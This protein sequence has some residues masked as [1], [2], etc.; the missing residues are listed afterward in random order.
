[1]L[2]TFFSSVFFFVK[3]YISYN[4]LDL[5]R[6]VFFFMLLQLVCFC[7]ILLVLRILVSF[8][9]LCIYCFPFSSL[10]L[11]L[12]LDIH[13][14]VTF[15]LFFVAFFIKF[16]TLFVF[17]CYLITHSYTISCAV[18][19]FKFYVFSSILFFCIFFLLHN[20]LQL[21]ER[22]AGWCVFQYLVFF[23]HIIFL[24]SFTFSLF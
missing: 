2:I 5:F 21:P 12:L 3:C 19:D 10:S 8:C 4:H 11:S 1:M 20:T 18:F 22:G 6:L 24:F 23:I 14:K 17:F 16:L 7:C 9:V 15:F 13:N